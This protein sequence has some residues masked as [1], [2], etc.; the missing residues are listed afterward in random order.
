MEIATTGLGCI[1]AVFTGLFISSG[2]CST[3]IIH[4]LLP[5]FIEQAA[6]CRFPICK[7]L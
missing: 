5:A 1:N 3:R 7:Q 6:T 4:T 2:M